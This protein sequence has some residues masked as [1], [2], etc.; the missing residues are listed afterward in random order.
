MDKGKAINKIMMTGQE[1][2]SIVGRPSS[3]WTD[4]VNFHCTALPGI[5]NWRT[6][7]KEWN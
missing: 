6:G 7:E 1:R 2:T 5:G 4:G 3:R